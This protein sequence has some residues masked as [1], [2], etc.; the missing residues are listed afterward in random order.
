MKKLSFILLVA[1]LLTSCQAAPT[2]SP[3]VAT[4]VPA[5]SVPIPTPTPADTEILAD[6]VYNVVGIWYAENGV[7][8]DISKGYGA[9]DLNISVY[10][11]GEDPW[12]RFA[13]ATGK[14]E[15]GKLIYL[16]VDGDCAGTEQATYEIYI[17]KHDGHVIGMMPKVVG[18]DPCATRKETLDHKLL[19]YVG[20]LFFTSKK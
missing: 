1:V 17:L 3:A 6:T 11:T 13:T 7:I 4:S 16:T 9:A 5:T 19:E 2:P 15:D 10:Y 8:L 14:F 18:D 12:S 20:V